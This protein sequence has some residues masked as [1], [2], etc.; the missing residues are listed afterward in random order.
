MKHER[1]VPEFHL[2]IFNLIG[3]PKLIR[4]NKFF[5]FSFLAS[6]TPLYCPCLE[7]L[8]APCNP[9]DKRTGPVYSIQLLKSDRKHLFLLYTKLSCQ[10]K[11][12]R[13][14]GRIRTFENRKKNTTKGVH[15]EVYTPQCT[16]LSWQ[17]RKLV[18]SDKLC[19]RSCL[20][21]G[22]EIVELSESQ[23]QCKTPLLPQSWA[24]E[25]PQTDSIHAHTEAATSAELQLFPGKAGRCCYFHGTN[26]TSWQVS[27]FPYRNTQNP[28][29]GKTSQP[30]T[31][32]QCEKGRGDTRMELA[33][34]WRESEERQQKDNVECKTHQYSVIRCCCATDGSGGAVWQNRIWH[35]SAYEKKV[36][37]WILPWRKNCIRRHSVML[38]ECL[39]GPSS[40][41]EHN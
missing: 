24:L 7:H 19:S 33:C 13:Q 38:A 25:Q 8:M 23:L 36:W 15:K 32:V 40:W 41:C 28:K 27:Y 16:A 12:L 17:A 30:F 5:F 22:G 14:Q 20:S 37:N 34:F 9:P 2:H 4:I 29:Q 26:A 35:G 1:Q 18:F 21:T 3:A 10:V 31:C 11:V 6:L 39:Q